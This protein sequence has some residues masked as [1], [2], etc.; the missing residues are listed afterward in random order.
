MQLTQ[1]AKRAQD[2]HK[3]HKA[4]QDK[5]VLQQEVPHMD[6]PQQQGTTR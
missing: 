4:K 5:A 1:R 2:K 3:E 6:K